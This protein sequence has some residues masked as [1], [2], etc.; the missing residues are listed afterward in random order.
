MVFSHVVAEIV[1]EY[2]EYGGH[3]NKKVGGFSIAATTWLWLEDWLEGRSPG[4][5]IQGHDKRARAWLI[6]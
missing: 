2:G 1:G 6:N 4:W 3:G 5:K